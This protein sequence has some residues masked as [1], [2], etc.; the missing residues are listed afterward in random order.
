MASSL[1]TFVVVSLVLQKKAAIIFEISVLQV[2]VATQRGF[3]PVDERMRVIDGNGK[4]VGCGF[5]F[6][7]GLMFRVSL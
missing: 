6:L 1:A 7:F 4:L 3:I 5:P 2:D